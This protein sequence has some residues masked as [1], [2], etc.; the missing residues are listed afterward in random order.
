MRKGNAPAAFLHGKFEING[1]DVGNVV[2][3][4]M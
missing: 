1:F 2:N 4:T 3:A